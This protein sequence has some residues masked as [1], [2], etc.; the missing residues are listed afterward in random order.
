MNPGKG[1][2]MDTLYTVA[3]PAQKAPE[4][5]EIGFSYTFCRTKSLEACEQAATAFHWIDYADDCALEQLLSGAQG[6]FI[7]VINSPELILSTAAVK[8]LL[9]FPF[10]LYDACGP[11][12]NKTAYP[13]QQAALSAPYLD[14]D[15]FEEVA[16]ALALH[17]APAYVSAANLDPACILCPINLLRALPP[18]TLISRL[19]ERLHERHAGRLAVAAQA[20]V[21]E[22][23]LGSLASPRE[24]LVQL[25]PEGTRRVLDIGCASGGYGRALKAAR[26]GIVVIGVELNPTLAAAAAP[27][28]N[29]LHVVPIEKL[30]LKTPVDLVNCG[31]VLE[32][33]QDPW[34]VLSQLHGLLKPGGCL[35]MSVPNAG[36]WTIARQILRGKFEYVPLG[37]LCV[38]HLRWFTETSI[39]KDL[40]KAGFAIDR[41]ERQQL[42]PT[43]EGAAFIDALCKS[44]YADHTSLRTNEFV[45]RAMRR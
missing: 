25:V 37:P 10:N 1:L 2:F 32:H 21:H 28:Y 9:D 3:W 12:F 6:K 39:R 41:F 36:H 4:I 11:A 23:F 15:S 27:H 13:Q 29:E 45:I 20:L 18:R 5:F 44:V 19:A 26:K 30:D 35:V 42:P 14:M 31:D 17:P 22:G 8:L 7:L 43:P 24:D 33:M 16:Q 38:G 34:T 40:E